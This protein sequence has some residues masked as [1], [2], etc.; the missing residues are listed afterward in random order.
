[1]NEL[2]WTQLIDRLQEGRLQQ[3]GLYVIVSGFV[4][5]IRGFTNSD[6]WLVTGLCRLTFFKLAAG[7][8]RVLSFGI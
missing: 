3:V 2:H 4:L 7:Q 5:S 6:M 1:M 8:R